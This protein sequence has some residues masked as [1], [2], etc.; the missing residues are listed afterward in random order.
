MAVGG[1]REA[2]PSLPPRPGVIVEHRRSGLGYP[3]AFSP[4]QAC[5]LYHCAAS[6]A[7]SPDTVRSQPAGSMVASSPAR[8]A[9][10]PGG[11]RR[12]VQPLSLP[13]GWLVDL[14]RVL[15]TK[16][17]LVELLLGEQLMRLQV[18]NGACASDRD[19]Q[20]GGADRVEPAAAGPAA[21]RTSR[22]P[23]TAIPS[24]R[25]FRPLYW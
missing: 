16:Q 7:E 12:L 9:R 2:S 21:A 11:R 10:A 4:A 15:G 3:R 1:R 24:L 18:L 20:R 13:T 8:A 19:T 5:H 25:I 17:H 6:D 22:M 23:A 14:R